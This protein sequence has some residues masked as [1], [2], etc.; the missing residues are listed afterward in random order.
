MKKWLCI[1]F[2]SILMTTTTACSSG[3]NGEL[4]S[5]EKPV[6][7]EG[8]TVVTLSMHRPSAF[9]QT[10]EKKFEEKYPDIDLQIQT[11][12]DYEK[13]QTT[14]NAVLLSGKGPD[15]FEI[16]SLPI[17]DY[18]SKKLL[19][20]MD[21][22]MEQDKTL[23]KSDLQMNV[24]DLM[25]QNGGMYAM[26]LG[27]SLRAFVGDGDLLKNANVDDKHWTWK[28]FE[29]VSRKLGG[30]DKER[31]YAL[32]NDPPDYFIQ[33]MMVD[34]YSEFVD[35]TTKKAK[36][37]SPL[38]VEVLKQIKKMYDD[39]V[40]TSESADIGKQMFYSTVLRSPADFINGLH[41]F[42][43]NPKL[44]QKPEQ[45]GGARILPESRFAI[46]AKSP[47]KEEAWKFIAFLLSDDGQSLQERE[48]FSLLKSV[49]EKQLNDIQNQV[50]SG[51]YKLEDGKAPKVS[52]EEFTQF[53]QFIRTADNFAIVGGRVIFIIGDESRAFFSEQKS[54]EE[55]AK[56]IQN[57]VTTY[58]NE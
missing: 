17:D 26:P 34:K 49:N 10:A 48:G 47:V 58:L 25:R 6:T 14:T 51:K 16:G 28:E 56:L 15:I 22:P 5:T 40:M 12:D 30:K 42:F 45:K 33:E 38:F 3:G 19:L 18:V 4:A 57:K 13:F 54:A 11:T 1:I 35:H 7:K 37:D 24:L 44:L 27:F 55:V 50:K 36:F 2:I 23:N 31:R 8:K 20:N 52:D 21:V 43:S 9:I 32:A 46:Q 41:Q 29:E 53:K 39:K